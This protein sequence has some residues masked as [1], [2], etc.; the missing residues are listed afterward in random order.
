MSRGAV[1]WSGHVLRMRRVL[2]LV[3]RPDRGIVDILSWRCAV[4]QGPTEK[5]VYAA[6]RPMWRLACQYTPAEGWLPM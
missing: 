4:G 3:T 6:A 5:C 2:E 1:L